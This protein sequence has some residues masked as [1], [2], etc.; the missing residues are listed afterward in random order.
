LPKKQLFIRPRPVVMR[1]LPAIHPSA[2]GNDH[3]QL[4]ETAR[5]RMQHELDVMRGKSV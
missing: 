4:L 3:K 2:V 1:I 5:T